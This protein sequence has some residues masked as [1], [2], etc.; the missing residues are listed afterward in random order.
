[1]RTRKIGTAAA[2]TYSYLG[3][4]EVVARLDDGIGGS[5]DVS[6]VLGA[7][8]SR[9][10]AVQTAPTSAS[11]FTVPDLHG[12]VAAALSTAGVINAALRYDGFGVLAST[13]YA[14]AGSPAMQWRFQGR[15]DV[16]DG[17]N[18]PVLYDMSAR[19]YSPGLGAFTSL[20]TVMGSAADPRSM[21]RY[22]YAAANPWSLVDPTGHCYDATTDRFVGTGG[23]NCEARMPRASLPSGG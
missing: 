20:D 4:S 7:D 15:L 14:A 21:N 1:M 17:T 18:A 16:A 10:M 3:D 22:L 6:S 12:N 13:P 19:N 8:A 9:L 11:G 5:P 2:T 23:G